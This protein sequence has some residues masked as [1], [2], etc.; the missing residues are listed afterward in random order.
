M[1]KQP[2][3]C[4]GET[5]IYDCEQA[6]ANLSPSFQKEATERNVIFVRKHV[7]QR[8]HKRYDSSWQNILAKNSKDAIAH[9]TKLGYTCFLHR[10]SENGKV[11][12]V[13]ETQLKRPIA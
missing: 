4:G 8:N 10:E 3:K 13:V 6:F 5:T 9:W 1:C 2:A 7:E 11:I 12:D